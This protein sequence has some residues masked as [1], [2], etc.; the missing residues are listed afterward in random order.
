MNEL[1]YLKL[2]HK[3]LANDLLRE[4]GGLLRDEDKIKMIKREKLHIKD[5]IEIMEKKR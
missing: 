1:A 5:N 4:E 3:K 2:K